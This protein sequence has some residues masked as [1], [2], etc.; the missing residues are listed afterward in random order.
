MYQGFG[1]VGTNLGQVAA[2]QFN[3]PPTVILDQGTGIGVLFMND[4][5]IPQ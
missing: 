5:R 1:Q 2:Q 4:V 3:T